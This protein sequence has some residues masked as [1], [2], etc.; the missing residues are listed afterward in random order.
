MCV[1]SPFLQDANYRQ[2][3]IRSLMLTDKGFCASG[4]HIGQTGSQEQWEVDSTIM[5]SLRMR[6]C[7]SRK[8]E[9]LAPSHSKDK[10]L[11]FVN[12]WPQIQREK[13][14]PVLLSI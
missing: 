9:E 8:S 12:S 5:P 11:R 13:G 3:L 7:R 2:L 1:F 10:M 6:K 4:G 14:Q